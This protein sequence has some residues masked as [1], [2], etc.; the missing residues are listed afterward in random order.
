MANS[1]EELQPFVEEL[2]RRHPDLSTLS[3]DDLVKYVETVL[4]V[5]FYR[6]RCEY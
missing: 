6:H 3:A 1:K 2:A 5:T 4:A